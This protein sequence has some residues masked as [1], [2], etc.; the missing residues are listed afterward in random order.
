MAIHTCKICELLIEAKDNEVGVTVRDSRK[1]YYYHTWCHEQY[2]QR[3]QIDT[4]YLT[5]DEPLPGG[6]GQDQC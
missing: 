3:I 6:A 1:K 2:Y 5:I 4:G